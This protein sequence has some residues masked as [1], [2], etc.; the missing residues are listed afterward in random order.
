MNSF[1]LNNGNSE[2]FKGICGKV[3]CTRTLGLLDIIGGGPH[4]LYVPS[5]L[6]YFDMFNWPGLIEFDQFPFCTPAADW[7]I[8]R[9]ENP[10]RGGG[11]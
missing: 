8:G 6:I 11:T 2:R 9:S 10:G 4:S 7:A 5:G 1:K 3:V